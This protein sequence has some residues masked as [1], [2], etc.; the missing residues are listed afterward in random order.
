MDGLAI[1]YLFGRMEMKAQ[2]QTRIAGRS[3][4]LVLAVM[5]CAA[6]Q[7]GTGQSPKAAAAPPSAAKPATSAPAQSGAAAAKQAAP[8][9]PAA[10]PAKPQAAPAKPPAAGAKP[11][12]AAAKPSQRQ[13]RP[14]DQIKKMVSLKMP[15]A[16]ILNQIK[17]Q[18]G[19][20]EATTNDLIEL[21]TLGASDAVILALS[22]GGAPA[23]PVADAAKSPGEAPR[24]AAVVAAATWNSDL[25]AIKCESAPSTRKRVIAVDEIDFG[26]VQKPEEKV[27][28]TNVDIGK[29][30]QALF[31]KRLV[32]QGK[33]TIVERRLVKEL[34]KEQD[35]AQ[36][37]RVKRG[38][39]A[40][41][42]RITGADA[43]LMG[44][45][46]VF[47][48]DDKKKK[49]GGFGTVWPWGGLLKF[50]WGTD[51]FV[52]A[53]S[54]RLVDAE[55][56]QIIEQGEARGEATRKSKGLD[57]GAMFPGGLGGGGY[58]EEQQAAQVIVGEAT[59]NCVDQLG[60]QL[61]SKEE[62]IPRKNWEIEARVAEVSGPQ[63]Y[64]AAGAN[65][66]VNKCD[67]FEVFRIVKEIPDP[68]TKEVIDFELKP[69][70][71]MVVTEVRDRVAIGPYSGTEPPETK[72]FLVK[73]KL[74]AK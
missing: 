51:K 2:K 42:G 1:R 18:P 29:G 34:L 23:A 48:R 74:M 57:T 50:K 13:V 30:I 59:I 65:D 60:E 55:T 25:S 8:A 38:T 72:K 67:R 5:G 26:T 27:F 31:V 62:K 64:I 56:S 17:N 52:L 9:T 10:S 24:E 20:M 46:T 21:K 36:S 7:Q 14:I 73:R 11:T 58:S 69:V 54:Y 61:N 28:G 39:G 3:A 6:G 70:G 47:G 41:T 15:E 68:E 22:G 40:R 35:F 53:V 71:E 66:G 16:A 12:A 49:L 19:G 32:E 44:T 33:F 63:V 43:I 37:S 45:I 4:I